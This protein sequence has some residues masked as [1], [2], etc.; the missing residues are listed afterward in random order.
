M[1]A[2]GGA[3]LLGGISSSTC[4]VR[5]SFLQNICTGPRSGISFGAAGPR[6]PSLS[7]RAP[8]GLQLCF[9]EGFIL[10]YFF[11]FLKFQ[12]FYFC[13][14]SRHLSPRLGLMMSG[15][16]GCEQQVSGDG[17]ER[18]SRCVSL[19]QVK[20]GGAFLIPDPLTSHLPR[21]HIPASTRLKDLILQMCL[22]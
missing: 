4:T 14:S 8:I 22:S 11:I 1:F 20:T 5:F 16:P 19:V 15:D 6:A 21:T 2:I 18:P 7:S 3:R 10:F 9:G 12:K 13:L 17:S